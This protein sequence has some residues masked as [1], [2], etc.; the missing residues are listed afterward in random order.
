MLDW[1]CYAYLC[2]FGS[3]S[4]SPTGLKLYLLDDLETWCPIQY[5]KLLDFC[6]SYGRI[7]HSNLECGDVSPL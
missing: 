1:S 3:T 5:E 7:G 6:Y 2:L 4:A